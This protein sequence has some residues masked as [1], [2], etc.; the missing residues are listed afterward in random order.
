[1]SSRSDLYRPIMLGHYLFLSF[2]PLILLLSAP[3]AFALNPSFQDVTLASGVQQR[4]PSLKFGGPLVADLDDDGHYDLVLSFHNGDRP[5]LYFG[6]ANGTFTFHPFR[7]SVADLHGFAAAQPCATSRRR[8]LS[9]SPG[10]GGG[11]ALKLPELFLFYP[12]RTIVEVTRSLGFGSTP[13]RG[14]NTLFLDLSRKSKR[15]RVQTCGGPDIIFVS[16][17]TQKVPSLK[18]FAYD[19]IGGRF[20]QRRL[21]GYEDEVRGHVELTDIDGDGIME[22]ISIQGLSIFA[23]SE[24]PG[25]PS[26][27]LDVSDRVLP[28]NFPFNRNDRTVH[29]VAEL[30]YDNDGDFD[31]YVARGDRSLLSRLG[32][33][34]TDTSDILL[35][36]RGGTYVDV[37]KAAGIPAGTESI[38]VTVADFNNDGFVDI[39]VILYREP[40]M[41]LLNQ[42]SGTFKRVD[43]LIPKP[44]TTVGNHAVA[45]DYNQDGKVDAIVGQGGDRPPFRGLYRIM[46]NV[47]P[48]RSTNRYLLVKVRSDPMLT[49]TALHAIVKVFIKGKMQTRRLGSRGAQAGGAS[50]IDTVHFGIGKSTRV[51]RVVVRWTSGLTAQRNNIAGNSKVTIG[52]L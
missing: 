1:M 24:T 23:I 20:R 11:K 27:F 19:N 14:R 39:L 33:R 43:R 2:L 21:P 52:R 28:S 6:S 45:V 12:N 42:G 34:R 48:L 16:L 51:D 5:Q 47:M 44:T 35:M 17:L 10:G 7:P 25:Q 38:G 50:Y 32:P 9:V 49:A 8:L 37:T 22:I 36:N 29:A 26:K 18:Q 40:D 15:R 13:V 31:L 3:P 30:D 4:R 46:K 41:L